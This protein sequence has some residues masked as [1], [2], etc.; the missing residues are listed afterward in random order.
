MN[1]RQERANQMV[2]SIDSVIVQL[3][4][5]TY[6]IKSQTNSNQSYIVKDTGHGLVCECP[7]HQTRKSD[8]KHIKITLK[9]VKIDRNYD[10]SFRVM[11][12]KEITLCRYCDSG[13]IMRNGFR[14]T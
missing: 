13:N 6:Q 9:H 5:K 4:E 7:D 3:D 10:E 12:R 2:E 14:H 11:E 8:C 1:K